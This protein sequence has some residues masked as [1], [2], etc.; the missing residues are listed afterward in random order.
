MTGRMDSEVESYDGTWRDTY[1]WLLILRAFRIS[2]G[3]QSLAVAGVCAAL[4]S[5]GWHVS[6]NCFLA[7]LVSEAAVSTG[8]GAATGS[9]S[10]DNTSDNL[11]SSAREQTKDRTAAIVA[12]DNAFLT[13]S[14]GVRRAPSLPSVRLLGGAGA[15]ERTLD[16]APCDPV[17]S[18]PVRVVLP[19]I[20]LFRRDLSFGQLA[21][22]LAGGIFTLFVWSIGGT[23]IAR[24]AL[25]QIGREDRMNMGTALTFAFQNFQSVLGATLMPMFGV[26][27]LLLPV[28]ALSLIMRIGIGTLMVGLIWPLVIIVAAI[29]A[30]ML[31][32]ILF[33]W[34][35][36]N[37]ALA[38]EGTDAFDC[39]SR[40]YAYSVQRPWKFLC[41]GLFAA[42]VGLI[43]WLVV[44]G[45]SESVIALSFWSVTWGFGQDNV[46]S[47]VS[48]VDGLTGLGWAGAKLIHFWTAVART[49][50]SGF[51]YSF[52][53]A[54]TSC[55]YLLLRHDVD[56]TEWDH[57]FDSRSHGI[58]YGLPTIEPPPEPVNGD[59][60]LSKATGA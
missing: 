39:V 16:R 29:M 52:F 31:M 40:A 51:G 33:G 10:A 11:G 4:V 9:T 32:G 45:F 41:Y 56:S 21:Y 43:G 42:M 50:A 14:P 59:A 17:L 49:I 30:I 57:V 38:A 13:K 53:W 19:A 25:V 36:V 60:T 37:A 55:I 8:E 23:T 58:V 1:P 6:A 2:V 46:A 12:A 47:V 22:Y 15:I 44:W 27:L 54:S 5:V 48:N 26:L 34:P 3:L 18:M 24:L 35:L 7:P 28:A 20:R